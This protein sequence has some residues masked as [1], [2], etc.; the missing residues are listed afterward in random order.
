MK[1][2]EAFPFARRVLGVQGFDR[3]TRA[4]E[5][6]V[7]GEDRQE[8]TGVRL[9]FINLSRAS[10]AELFDRAIEKFLSHPGWDEL[11]Q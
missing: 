7:V 3:S 8:Q 1:Q 5:L 11:K 9:K 6:G 2:E 4:C 10:S